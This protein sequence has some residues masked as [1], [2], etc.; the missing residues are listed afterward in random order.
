[1]GS[2]RLRRS[3]DDPCSGRAHMAPGHSSLQQ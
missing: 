1:M 2:R 3:G